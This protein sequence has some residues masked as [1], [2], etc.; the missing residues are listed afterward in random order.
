MSIQRILTTAI[1]RTAFDC[2]I[3]VFHYHNKLT[4]IVFTIQHIFIHIQCQCNCIYE[5]FH[6]SEETCKNPSQSSF[7]SVRI[8]CVGTVD[9]LLK[10]AGKSKSEVHRRVVR[11]CLQGQP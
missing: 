7:G 5:I 6:Q 11:Y 8:C 2:Y 10:I 9:I 1:F 3:R 4:I